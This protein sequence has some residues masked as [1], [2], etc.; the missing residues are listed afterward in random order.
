VTVV[1]LARVR[2]S[3]AFSKPEAAGGA[4]AA[5]AAAAPTSHTFRV[6]GRDV[7]DFSDGF[8]YL[9]AQGAPD[10]KPRLITL[11]LRSYDVMPPTLRVTSVRATPAGEVLVAYEAADAHS[12]VARVGM[13]VTRS[14]APIEAAALLT[15]GAGVDLP[16]AG[17]EPKQHVYRVA[18]RESWAPLRFALVAV[19]G[20]GNVSQPVV[21]PL[22]IQNNG[23][24]TCDT[25]PPELRRTSPVDRSFV[26]GVYT[27][28]S[29]YAA[30]D[31]SDH[32]AGFYAAA[33]PEQQQQQGGGGGIATPPRP[34]DI[35]AGAAD[36]SSA[37]P[38]GRASFTVAGPG[39]YRVHAVDA[40]ANVGQAPDPPLVIVRDAAPPA[41]TAKVLSIGMSAAALRVRA[42][43]DA[44]VASPRVAV[45]AA[46]REPPSFAD[47]F[48]GEEELAPAPAAGTGGRAYPGGATAVE[49]D[50]A[51]KALLEG[52][53]YRCYACAR[54]M[55]G[56]ETVT[57]AIAA[58]RTT[59]GDQYMA[60]PLAVT[61]RRA[62]SFDVLVD[63]RYGVRLR[64]MRAYAARW[65][66]ATPPR[67]PAAPTHAKVLALGDAVKSGTAT[68]TRFYGPS[69]AQ[70]LTHTSRYTVQVAAVDAAGRV[71]SFPRLDATTLDET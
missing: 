6:P 9:V 3:L 34:V 13:L 19:D 51:F 63:V 24:R 28:S 23:G 64:S 40:Q 66:A 47:D 39:A 4:A 57:G 65:S 31:N 26:A 60:S 42:E 50:V 52:T 56:N 44:A 69:G 16:T 20:G 12:G 37:A 55:F 14:E 27:V 11:P 41:V 45:V 30:S 29:V 54:D 59:T 43:D 48:E 71:V 7:V 70:P 33:V 17:A 35:A 36:F 21:T 22:A 38:R 1:Q 5:A 58:F 32:L 25:V 53:E 68:M 2:P 62:D 8:V 67:R 10:G 61:A 46:A 49:R 15:D 18:T